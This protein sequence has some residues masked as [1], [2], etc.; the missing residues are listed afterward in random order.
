MRRY[1]NPKKYDAQIDE[2]KVKCSCNHTIVMPVYADFL[3]CSHCKKKVLNNT[4][5]HFRYKMRKE[6]L[7]NKEK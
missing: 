1:E 6:M 2:I 7:K 3:I 5:A 4:K